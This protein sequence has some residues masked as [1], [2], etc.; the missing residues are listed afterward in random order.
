MR[1]MPT[2]LTFQELKNKQREIRDGFPEGFA[3]RIHRAISWVGRAEKD[4]DD[5]DATFL[6]YWISFNAAYAD[7]RDV[8][9]ERDMFNWLFT[10][11]TEL[12]TE[13]RLYTAVWSRFTG[14]IRLFLEN[15]Y[16]FSPFWSHHNGHTGFEDWPDRFDSARI[17]FHRA[18][19]EQRTVDILSMLFDR[20]YVLRNQLIHGGATWNSN[21]NRD[22][23]RDGA[24]ILS[25][26]MPL[27]IDIM[28][29]NAHE[30]WGKPFYPVVDG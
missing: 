13:N 25:V 16:V 26:L 9:N 27:M 18:L 15:Q 3:L 4:R 8:Q 24:A 23:L 28:M 29:E 30:E 21:V 6:F 11:L 2:D 5:L 12:D 20:L 7:E 22:Q 19:A 10:R 17:A 14:P 1:N